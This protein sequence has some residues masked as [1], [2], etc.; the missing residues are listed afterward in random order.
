MLRKKSNITMLLAILSALILFFILPNNK[1][2][3]VIVGSLTLTTVLTIFSYPQQGKS[4]A[5]LLLKRSLAAIV[6]NL[7]IA[8]PVVA[9][10]VWI[11]HYLS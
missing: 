11:A 3:Q 4:A 10:M 2:A 5:D 9:A 6:F 8:V 7:L 1:T